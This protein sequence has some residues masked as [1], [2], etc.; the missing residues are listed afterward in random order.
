[1]NRIL[2]LK[3]PHGTNYSML[4]ITNDICQQLTLWQ[5]QTLCWQHYLHVTNTNSMLTVS[6]SVVLSPT[7]SIAD[8]SCSSSRRFA[9]SNFTISWSLND[10]ITS[11]LII[12]R[13]SGISHW[14]WSSPL[15]QCYALPGYSLIISAE[16]AHYTI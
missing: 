14:L 15:Q 1:M 3:K 8:W 6:S 12:L 2:H 7:S 10:T 13:Q 4:T 16:K 11:I 5:W 9:S